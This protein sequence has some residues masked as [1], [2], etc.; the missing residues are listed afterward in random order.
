M[1]MINK[2][3]VAAAQRNQGPLAS[4]SSLIRGRRGKGTLI[5]LCRISCPKFF[6]VFQRPVDQPHHCLSCCCASEG[7]K[8][9]VFARAV[10]H[11]VPSSSSSLPHRHH[12]QLS[13]GPLGWLVGVSLGGAIGHQLSLDSV[14]FGRTAGR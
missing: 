6:K 7:A 14:W 1:M 10:Q 5:A 12:K 11:L 13:N 2:R 4:S 3:L 8:D 9:R